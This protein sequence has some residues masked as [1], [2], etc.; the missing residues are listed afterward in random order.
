[1]QLARSLAVALG[2]GLALASQTPAAMAQAGNPDFSQPSQPKP[3]P[4]N[5]RPSDSDRPSTGPVD[6]RPKFRPGTEVR[7]AFQQR[8]AS[9]FTPTDDPKAKQDQKMDQSIG[10]LMRVTEASD[11]GATLQIVYESVRIK[12]VTPDDKGEFDS[13]RPES[14]KPAPGQTGKPPA[15][16]KSSPPAPP[17]PDRAFPAIP[18]LPDDMSLDSMLKMIAGP[19]VG[20]I[21]T[22]KTDASGQ[23]TSVSGGESLGGGALAGLGGLGGGLGGAMMPHPSQ[24]AN[25]L[26]ASIGGRPS[27]RVGESWT[28]SDKLAGSPVGSFDMNTTHTLRSHNGSVASIAF[29]GST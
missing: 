11:Q 4:S 16:G 19:S 22:V 27:A 9:V 24:M 13:T 17:V 18:G 23:I 21:I 2:L 1:M 20:T 6:L 14:P 25:W 12:L 26:V 7:Y 28:N 8:S 15:P 29:A 10:L 3:A 5:P